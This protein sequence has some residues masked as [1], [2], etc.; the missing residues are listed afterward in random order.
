MVCVLFSLLFLYF[1]T[2]LDSLETMA[3][4]HEITLSRP[5]KLILQHQHLTLSLT[6]SYGSFFASNFRQSFGEG[7]LGHQLILCQASCLS[8]VDFESSR[9]NSNSINIDHRH[10]QSQLKSSPD[11]DTESQPSY[12]VQMAGCQPSRKRQ[13][14]SKEGD[15]RCQEVESTVSR[16]RLPLTRVQ[17]PGPIFFSLSRRSKAATAL[18]I[19]SLP[20]WHT[21]AV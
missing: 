8:P 4:R 20:V 7:N 15:C 21:E 17:H 2:H 6:D 14:R 19:L 9:I 5:Q 11:E 3:E 18:Q 1:Q 12:P 13:N 10:C 16:R